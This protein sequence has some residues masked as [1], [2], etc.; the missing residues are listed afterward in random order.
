MWPWWWSLCCADS[1]PKD[2][3]GWIIGYATSDDRGASSRIR[4]FTHW[5]F[6]CTNVTQASQLGFENLWWIGDTGW[7][8]SFCI[9]STD[10]RRTTQQPAMRGVTITDTC[11]V[12]KEE[13]A[14][15][16]EAGQGSYVWSFVWWR[17]YRID[18]GCDR[19]KWCCDW[20]EYYQSSTERQPALLLPPVSKLKVVRKT[21]GLKA[22]P[23]VKKAIA[24]KKWMWLTRPA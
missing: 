19:W 4:C 3:T 13:T 2:P 8:H 11:A 9:C 12:E 21:K 10:Q 5:Q 6:N 18:A 1:P 22:M 16:A 17:E 7:G 15:E 23:L 20:D 24:A 14:I